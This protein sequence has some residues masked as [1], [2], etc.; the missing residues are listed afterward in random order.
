MRSTGTADRFEQV[1]Y[2]CLCSI[3]IS[4]CRQLTWVNLLAIFS[5]DKKGNAN[6]QKKL[7]NCKTDAPTYIRSIYLE[8]RKVKLFHTQMLLST[9]SWAWLSYRVRE[10]H[11][12]HTLQTIFFLLGTVTGNI[13]DK[14]S[15]FAAAAASTIHFFSSSSG[16]RL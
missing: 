10:R 5:C 2:S 15:K 12:S 8:V 16:C 4:T 1:S 6:R 7:T 3:F 14:I 9:Q 11:C 13:D